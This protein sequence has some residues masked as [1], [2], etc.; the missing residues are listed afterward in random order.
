MID[1]L[2]IGITHLLMALAA[3]RMLSRADLD[4]EPE[5]ASEAAPARGP[6]NEMR[7]PGV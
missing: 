5:G 3:F 1:N 4:R 2:A 7:L 6:R